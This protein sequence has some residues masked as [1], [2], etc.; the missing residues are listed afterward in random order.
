MAEKIQQLQTA[1]QLYDEGKYT[2]A[3][4]AYHDALSEANEVKEKSVI[5]AELSWAY[6]NTNQFDKV[7]PIIEEVLKSDPKYGAREDL[8]RIRGFSY[9]ALGDDQAGLDDLNESLKTDRNSDKQQPIY[10]E[11][12]KLYFKYQQYPQALEHFE[13]VEAYYYQ[14]DQE[15]W[16]SILFYKGFVFYYQNNLDEAEKI[17]EELLD[18]A[19]ESKRKATALFGLAF[20][21]Y[22]RKDY[23]KTINICESVMTHD[24]VFFDK[25]T[26]AFLTAC[27]FHYLG[28]DDVFISYYKELIKSFPDGRYKQELNQINESIIKK[29]DSE[30]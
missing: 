10:F 17:F 26:T 13:Q 29:R 12:G 30:K 15:Y 1:R 18:S 28:R 25:E 5:N 24:P 2:E 6:Y 14:N 22:A 21:V 3:I 11:I 8:L 27:S 23:L 7:V 19:K 16:L 9:I 20:I 4:P